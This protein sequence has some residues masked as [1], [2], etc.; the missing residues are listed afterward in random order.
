MRENSIRIEK[1]ASVVS[2]TATKT[3]PE[4]EVEHKFYAPISLPSIGCV[5][6]KFVYLALQVR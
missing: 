4:K 2:I 3:P 6:A 1:L 5:D